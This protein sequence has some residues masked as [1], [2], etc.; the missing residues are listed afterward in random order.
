MYL[1]LEMLLTLLLLRRRIELLG[2]FLSSDEWLLILF[3]AGVAAAISFLLAQ[4]VIKHRLDFLR[5]IDIGK[6]RW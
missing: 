3:L 4:R 5:Q 1:S 6:S 2:D